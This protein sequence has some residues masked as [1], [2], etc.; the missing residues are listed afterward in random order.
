ML[1]SGATV[2]S[3]PHLTIGIVIELIIIGGFWEEI[4]WTGYALPT[5]RN[6]FANRAN[7]PLIAALVLG[8]FR[9][10]WHLPLLLYGQI[11]WFDVL[12]F[13]VAVQLIIAWIFFG[14]GGSLPAVML[15]H[16]I[17]NIMGSLMYPV[18]AGADRTMYY[19]I[20]MGLACLVALVIAWKTGPSLGSAASGESQ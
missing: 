17:S 8:V 16:F 7:G 12:F 3:P 5:L 6:R 9:S 20:F 1:L 10:I 4:G 13:A 15:F 11:P 19:A 14:S 2:A 18:I